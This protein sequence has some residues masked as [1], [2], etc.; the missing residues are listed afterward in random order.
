MTKTPKTDAL[1]ATL[2]LA[3]AHEWKRQQDPTM[4][5]ETTLLDPAD[6]GRGQADRVQDALDAIL[7]AHYGGVAHYGASTEWVVTLNPGTRNAV[8][9]IYRNATEAAALVAQYIAEGK[10]VACHQDHA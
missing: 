7:T 10:A 5:V 9:T 4:W 1:I 2:T 3:Q 6:I 8:A